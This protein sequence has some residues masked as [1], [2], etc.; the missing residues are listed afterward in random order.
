MISII[1]NKMM[2]LFLGNIGESAA[3]SI[4]GSDVETLVESF[5]MAICFHPL[6]SALVAQRQLHV[7]H[8]ELSEG[9][10]DLQN[11][12]REGVMPW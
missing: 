1:Y 6:V 2:V 10:R 4:L 7:S 11:P 5:H 9:Y 3:M 12:E 8:Q